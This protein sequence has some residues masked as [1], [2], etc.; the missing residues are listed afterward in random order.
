[1][2]GYNFSMP[3]VRR[4]PL[5]ESDLVKI[6]EQW[7]DDRVVHSLL[8]EI[9]RLRRS[10]RL[11]FDRTLTLYSY[12]PRETIVPDDAAIDR[13]LEIEPAIIDDAQKKRARFDAETHAR[14]LKRK[15]REIRS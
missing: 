11:L 7:G 14:E 9:A 5:T 2:F 10:V 3:P 6:R 1:M 4:R 12:I 15:A 13:L 8:W